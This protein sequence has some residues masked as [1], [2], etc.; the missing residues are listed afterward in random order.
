MIECIF[1]SVNNGYLPK[2]RILAASVRRHHP[3]AKMALMLS[4]HQDP[5]LDYSD[6]DIVLTPD[7]VVEGVGELQSWLFDHTVVELCTAVKPFAFAHLFK[8]YDFANVVYQD[9]DTVLY[10]RLEE[11]EKEMVTHPIVLTPHVS[12]PATDTDDLQDGEM[13]GCL[14]HGVFNLGF[15]ALTRE[16]EGP[17]FLQWWLDRCRDYCFDDNQRGLFT[18]QKWVDL[19]PCFFQTLGILRVPSYNVATW[20]LYYREVSTRADGT[21]VVNGTY[22]LR[23][24]HFSGFDI[25]THER[26]LGKHD[27][28]N[29][30]LQSMTQWYTSE[31]ER[32]K[33]PA[34]L[35]DKYGVFANG[36][37]I[38]A[39]WRR[40]YR[41]QPALKRMIPRPYEQYEAIIAHFDSAPDEV[42]LDPS[43]SALERFVRRRPALEAIVR[44]IVPSSVIRRIKR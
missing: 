26:M 15:L 33:N 34:G 31:L 36:R 19:A 1:T 38:P 42:A 16:G 6:F 12:V 11:L 29:T 2:A 30:T 21:I 9:P 43:R 14:R 41:S 24:Y 37:K 10:A 40:Y 4:D 8:K 5:A 27:A 22:P 32:L 35:P 20:N 39:D 18:D 17:A 25:G 7:D 13:L 23:F 3:E 44:K 28:G